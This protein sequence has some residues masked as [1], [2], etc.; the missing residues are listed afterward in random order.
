MAIITGFCAIVDGGVTAE[1]DGPPGALY[2]ARALVALGVE[3]VL[4][5]DCHAL[6]LLAAGCAAWQLDARMLVEFP[7]ESCD[8]WIDAFLASPRGERL[9]HLVAI[10]RPAPSHTLDS[11]AAQRRAGEP[12]VE[13]FAAEVPPNDRDVS[14]NMRGQS[15]DRWTAPIHRLFAAVARRMPEVATIGIGDGGNEL[16]MGRYPWELLVEALGAGSG[17]IVARVAADWAPVAGVSDWAAYALALAATRLRGATALGRSWTA[18]AQRSLVETI[19]ERTNA[20]DGV[21]LRREAT[22]DGLPLDA[23]L[24]PLVAMRSLLGFDG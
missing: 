22:V 7:F 5:T 11:L 23:Y 16:G 24:E 18:A 4:V 6:P 1:T 15:I 8:E 2:L 14:H 13:R 17:A 19:V 9:T 3:V 12:P 10:E 21:T 20:V